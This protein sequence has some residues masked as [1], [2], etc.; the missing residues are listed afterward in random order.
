[1]AA[2]DIDDDRDPDHQA[3]V[4]TLPAPRDPRADDV[5]PCPRCAQCQFCQGS[6][7]VSRYVAFLL[8]VSRGAR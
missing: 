8:S 4:E 6:G 5:V 1:M 2:D 3:T 7:L